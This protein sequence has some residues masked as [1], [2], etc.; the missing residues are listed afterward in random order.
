MSTRDSLE[1]L[2]EKNNLD[3]DE[4]YKKVRETLVLGVFEVICKEIEKQGTRTK[5]LGLFRRSADELV[6]TKLIVKNYSGCDLDDDDYLTISQYLRAFFT[7]GSSRIFFTKDC[8]YSG[9]LS[10]KSGLLQAEL[11]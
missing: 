6:A 7:K 1:L 5:E 11:A 8:K 4:F 9:V 3:C 2:L 10:T